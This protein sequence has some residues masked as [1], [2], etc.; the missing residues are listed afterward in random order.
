MKGK[1]ES[2]GFLVGNSFWEELVAADSQEKG[3]RGRG[4]AYPL[5]IFCKPLKTSFQIRVSYQDILQTAR[6]ILANSCFG[7]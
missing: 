2:C 1:E 7:P 3:R 5:P 4:S 6:D